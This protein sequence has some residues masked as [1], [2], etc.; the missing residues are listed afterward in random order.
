MD[1]N[2]LR[3][4]PAFYR[5]IRHYRDRIGIKDGRP[6]VAVRFVRAVQELVAKL[7]KNPQRGHLAGFEAPELTDILR[8]SVPGFSVFA[9]FYRWDG[10]TLTV[11][12]L[13]HT[14]QNLPSRLASMVSNPRQPS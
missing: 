11:I 4:H 13:E 2:K 6:Q 12:T 9:L 1:T 7:L 10:Q 14:A 8:A 3:V 5:R